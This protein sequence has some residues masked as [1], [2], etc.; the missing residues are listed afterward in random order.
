MTIS[1]KVVWMLDCSQQYLLEPKWQLLMGK[2]MPSRNMKVNRNG[3]CRGCYEMFLLE[4]GLQF[5]NGSW[6][7]LASKKLAKVK[8]L[9]LCAVVIGKSNSM[10]FILEALGKRIREHRTRKGWSQE[11]FADE[12][13]INRS[14]MGEV[15]RGETNLTFSTLY[16]ISQKLEVTVASLFQGIA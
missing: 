4:A 16:H 5:L 3:V 14:H 8:Q 15:E 1:E 10:K 12:C 6:L 13:G 9:A 2:N 11:A 7:K